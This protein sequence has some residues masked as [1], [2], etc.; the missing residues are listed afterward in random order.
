MAD[1][2]RTIGWILTARD[3]A[4]RPMRKATEFLQ[5]QADKTS[6]A[7]VN[8]SNTLN[9]RW[10]RGGLVDKALTGIAGSFVNVFSGPVT[11][12]MQKTVDVAESVTDR[13]EK[14]MTSVSQKVG[15]VLD[16]VKDKGRAAMEAL[17][18]RDW[19][20][21]E[22]FEAGAKTAKKFGQTIK[23]A[24]GTA[25][26]KAR[27]L[28][29]GVGEVFSKLG[30]VGDVLKGV[31]KM[32][33][34]G[35]VLLGPLGPLLNLFSPLIEMFTRQFTPAI[36]TFSAIV[37][38]AFGP[39]S[40][41][42][43][44][45]ARN[46]ALQLVPIIRPLGA[47]LELAA[48]QIGML[49]TDLLKGKPDKMFA[50]IFKA[51]KD[52]GPI[53][54]RILNVLIEVGQE[55]GG[56]LL[57]AFLELAPLAIKTFGSFLKAVTPL[58]KPLTKLAVTL[59]KKVF[60]PMLLKF[61]QILDKHIIP[62]IDEWAP[63]A[64]DVIDDIADAVADFYGQ[65]PKYAKDFY[66][67]FIKPVID[68]I[69][70]IKDKVVELARG[71]KR[72]VVD[73]ITEAMQPLFDKVEKL[74]EAFNDLS[75]RTAERNKAAEAT[76]AANRGRALAENARSQLA[77]QAG[78]G[79]LTGQA[80][81]QKLD[82]FIRQQRR[83]RGMAEGGVVTGPLEALI[84]EGQHKELV[85][86]LERQTIERTLAPLMPN[87]VP[88]MDKVVELGEELLRLLRRGVKVDTGQSDPP[89]PAA[90]PRADRGHSL[91]MSLGM[92]GSGGF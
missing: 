82:D 1:G 19:T 40:E 68:W 61:V 59:L 45:I 81:R 21:S 36:E 17:F 51:F 69:G 33:G 27:S 74:V 55:V 76:A 80:R 62:F 57:D 91:G 49:V 2:F 60:I 66:T 29:V 35:G 67:L 90:G 72:T 28:V 86:P 92:A 11:T 16:M 56:T 83:R 41:T 6:N 37:E 43:E 14:A 4:T 24:L 39:F 87:L 78:L 46:I 58:I 70:D 48:V 13:I 63:V 89:P 18:Y 15:G 20:F 47:F 12:A 5:K 32:G 34:I 88:N 53:I 31:K 54:T 50:V 42:L 7:F 75:G 38:T 71:F 65:F 23:G 73:P 52:I 3:V 26:T 10:A 79:N 30:G 25:V 44:I 84:G 85:L 64:A 77:V 9:D 8:M 22:L